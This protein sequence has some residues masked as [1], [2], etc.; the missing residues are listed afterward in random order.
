MPL[1]LVGKLTFKAYHIKA[2]ALYRNNIY[3]WC[4]YFNFIYIKY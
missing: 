4:T 1:H 2:V 3:V